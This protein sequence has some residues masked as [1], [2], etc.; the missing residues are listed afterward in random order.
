MS[1]RDSLT[2]EFVSLSEQAVQVRAEVYEVREQVNG[3][4]RVLEEM[5][6]E[7]RKK[8]EGR[9]HGLA[10]GVDPEV[11]RRMSTKFEAVVSD[12]KENHDIADL[13]REI[14]AMKLEIAHMPKPH[15]L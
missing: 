3:R 8:G 13:R 12:K 9:G 6:E 1:L 4:V 5:L 11:R 14:A 10:G 2:N 7:V 15:H